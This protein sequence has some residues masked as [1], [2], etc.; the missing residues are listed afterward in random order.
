MIYDTIILGGGAAG[1]FC[2]AHLQKGNTLLLD[3]NASL[4][5]KIA[6]SGGGRCNITNEVVSEDNYLCDKSFVK[7]LLN[8]YTQDDVMDFFHQRGLKTV[9]EKNRQFFCQ[10]SAK[11]LIDILLSETR[12]IAV[13]KSELIDLVKF[14]EVF[15]VKTNLSSYK[16][17]NLLIATGGPCLPK[18]GAS[19]I[20]LGL[21]GYFGHEHRVFE[22]VLVGL[23]LQP[24]QFWMKE[25]SGVSFKASVTVGRKS[26]TDQLLFAHKGISGPAVLSASLYWKKSSI[27]IDF[28]PDMKLKQIFKEKKKLISNQIPLP[29]RFVKAFLDAIG[30]EDKAVGKLTSNEQ[31]KLSLLKSYNFSPAGNFGLARAEAT[32]GGVLTDDIDNKTM[33]SNLQEGLYFAGEVVD[34]TGELGGYNFQW[35]FSSAKAVADALNSKL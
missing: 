22:P 11:D 4:G 24:E 23:S 35:A 2:A 12:Q 20:G 7:P 8:A 29:K 32:R 28:L 31:E 3:A 1:L 6:I 17:K 16:A 13:K 30:L 15:I 10:H 18:I 34:V 27:I 14:D 26:F 9:V 33:Q 21:A 5:K 19:D 25:L